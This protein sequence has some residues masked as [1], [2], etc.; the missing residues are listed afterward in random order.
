MICTLCLKEITEEQETVTVLDRIRHKECS[1]KLKEMID[2][3][4]EIYEQDQK[5]EDI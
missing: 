2:E 5:D 1:D 3:L 4:E